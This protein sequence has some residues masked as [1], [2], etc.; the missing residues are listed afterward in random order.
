M[1]GIGGFVGWSLVVGES[2]VSTNEK[3]YLDYI[4]IFIERIT[5]IIGFF[6]EIVNSMI[7]YNRFRHLYSYFT[8]FLLYFPSSLLHK[9]PPFSHYPSG[10]I[11]TLPSLFKPFIFNMFST[12]NSPLSCSRNISDMTEVCFP[13]VVK[14]IQTLRFPCVA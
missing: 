11:Y 2:I 10:I 3:I 4:S 13:P 6:L 14:N 7:P 1:S 9:E 12:A 5:C 8:L